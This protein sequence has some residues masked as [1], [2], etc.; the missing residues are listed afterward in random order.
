VIITD[1]IGSAQQVAGYPPGQRAAMFIRAGGTI[2]L[3]VNPYIVAAMAA[4]LIQRARTDS[5]FRAQV[6]AAALV[7]LRAKL[8]RGLLR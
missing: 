5:A 6:N 8:A 1:D 2:V 7:V 3:T 4:R